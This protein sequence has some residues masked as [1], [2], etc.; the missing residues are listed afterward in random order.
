MASKRKP[1]GFRSG[2]SGQLS[3]TSKHDAER[4]LRE[5]S[6]LNRLEESA[7]A[8]EVLVERRAR[9]QSHAEA[10]GLRLVSMN[11]TD[12]AL[13]DPALEAIPKADLNRI[14]AISDNLRDR[15][16]AHV[17]ELDRLIE[18]HPNL[19]VLRN[20]L[21]VA[22]EAAGEKERAKKVVEETAR[23]F[24]SYIFGF[25]NQVSSLLH[26]GKV[27]EAKA[28]LETGPRGPLLLLPLFDPSREVFHTSEAVAYGV[29]LGQYFLATERVA[30]AEAQL[31][32]LE[33]IAPDHP[34]LE[35]LSDAIAHQHVI[36]A[37][38]SLRKKAL[39]PRSKNKKRGSARSEKATKDNPSV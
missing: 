29:M 27:E 19:P 20:F 37:I 25:C 12:E 8:E 21:T 34:H 13:P 5:T 33:G 15:P 32:M 7:G 31:E 23:L 24:P 22:L 10:M 9:L 35:W 14:E 4:L 2:Y 11:I 30:A 6:R 3:P 18:K 28:M 16:E 36:S 39:Q 17:E 1:S 38:H 26:A